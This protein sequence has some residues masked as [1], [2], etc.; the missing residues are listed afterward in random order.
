MT[1][2]FTF[3]ANKEDFTADNGVTYTW[4]ANRWRVKKYK[5]DDSKLSEYLPLAGGEM[6]G[7]I[8]AGGHVVTNLGNPEYSGHATPRRY[9]DEADQE[10]QLEIDN[11]KQEIEHLAPSF[12]RGE[13]T[14]TEPWPQ[15]G[16]Y[17]LYKTTSYE[18]A[19]AALQEQLLECQRDC[20]GDPMCSSGC[21]RMYEAAMSEIEQYDPEKGGSGFIDEPERDWE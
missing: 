1:T 16:Q 20:A 8:S 12:E 3:P 5:L 2:T 21:T 13:W 18:D 11:L 17:G 19:A 7:D 9:V 15:A 6:E 4:D 10:L 14:L